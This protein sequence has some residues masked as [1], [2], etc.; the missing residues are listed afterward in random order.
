M[1]VDVVSIQKKK[2]PVLQ[3]R[4]CYPFGNS[5]G[6]DALDF[7]AGNEF[8]DINNKNKRKHNTQE[9]KN[10]KKHKPLQKPNYPFT[11]KPYDVME[12]LMDYYHV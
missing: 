12:N 9:E 11:S 6:D 8:H 10:T 7:Y 2:E 4:Q 5:I 3:N 1:M